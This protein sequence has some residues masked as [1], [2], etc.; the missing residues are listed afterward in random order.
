MSLEIEAD[1]EKQ[2]LFPPSLEELLSPDHPAR[3]VR[4]FVDQQDLAALGFKTRKAEEGR[5]SYS[6]K[7]LLKV[8][9]YGYV[10]GTRSCR[11]LE[12]ACLDQMGMLWLTGMNSP[13]HTTLWR[14]WR[15][16]QKPIR[17][18][19]KQLL[20]VA[21]RLNLI[22]LVLHAVDGT[23]ILSAASDVNGLHRSKLKERLQR[24]DEAID[25]ILKQTEQASGE[26]SGECR[27]PDG[28]QNK[29][30]LRDKIQEQLDLLDLEGRDHL[31]PG[32]ED[33]RVMRSAGQNRFAY[34]AQAV[35]DEASGLI[36]AADVVTDESDNYQLVPM[37]DEVKENLGKVAEQ[38]VA[39]AG[40][41]AITGLAEAEG[42]N[43]SVMVNLAEP[44]GPWD[45]SRFVYDA[46]ND[47]C[48]CPR[49]ERLEFQ[50]LKK[51][52]KAEPYRVRV[53]RC[54]NYVDCPVRWQ[55]SPSQTGRTVQIHP[56]HDVL[57]R[58]REKH[59]DETLRAALKKRSKTIEP[60]FAWCKQGMNFRRWTVRGLEKVKTQWLLLCTAINLRRL[61][62]QWA[63]GKLSFT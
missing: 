48:I 1:Y 25:E 14:F 49:G 37:L 59:K 58:Q 30:E 4:E 8:W 32:D 16:N 6:V 23:K 29:Q 7:L 35:A 17:K 44:E 52:D 61:H 39:D 46:Q 21:L 57:V 41:K 53:Y 12:R 36:V 45:A 15:D 26:G 60:V 2:W 20:K 50:Y 3:M 40:Y 9:L 24:L 11:G 19:F 38:N 63:A 43:Y 5:P 22:G 27:L 13:D 18:T 10:S 62:K 55:C 47:Q 31:N 54:Q 33:A 34:N 51:R 42:K 28:L 56:N